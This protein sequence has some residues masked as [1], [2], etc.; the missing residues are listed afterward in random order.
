MK[1][2]KRTK[3]KIIEFEEEQEPPHFHK[4][5]ENARKVSIVEGSVASISTGLGQSYITPFA[6]ALNAQPIHIGFLSSFSGLI[7]PIAQIFGSKMME[8]Y[9]RKKIVLTFIFLQSIVWLTIGLLG[10]LFYK[11]F[12]QSYLPIA[13]IVLYSILLG[14]GGLA[15]PAWF[16]WMGDIIP[17]EKKGKYFS[18]R[19]RI[20]GTIGL[21]AF[22]GG[23]F[24]LDLFKT[25][26]FVLLGFGVIFTLA[27]IFR[28]ISYNLFHKQFSPKFRLR[29]QDYFSF[30]NFIKTFDNYGK[31]STYQALFYFALMIVAPFF[32]VYMLQEL[33]YTYVIFMV[34]TISASVAYLLFNPIAGKF[35][36]KFG[37]TKLL[38]IANVL[39]LLSP[40][41]WL[42]F[43]NPTTLIL[44]SQIPAGIAN[45]AFLMAITNFTYDAVSPRHR[46]ICLAYKGLLVGFG[47]FFGSILGGLL[48][49]FI[50]I[51]FKS[52]FFIIVII[53]VSL[54][55]IIGISFL[56]FI[57]D[58]RKVKHIPPMHINLTNPFKT[59]HAEIGWFRNVLK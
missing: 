35:S 40:L 20:T 45:A 56:P 38:W 22:L 23:A 6:L 57:K 1:Q 5:K 3:Q 19:N 13:L 53:S 51:S 37:N 9:S 44:T 43:K 4:L 16:S 46:P 29:K 28:F 58:E 24:I 34:V 14:F 31:F 39:F 17:E 41:P 8:K 27:F 11:D 30:T 47:T 33:K 26:G 15:H 21:L 32:A 36:D 50:P 48:I 10:Y 52:A 2:E 18:K 54:R 59:L 55:L 7:S 42:I 12:F 25:R 49:N